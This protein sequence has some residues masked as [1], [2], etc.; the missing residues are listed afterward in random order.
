M[1]QKLEIEN[2]KKRFKDIV[3]SI[4]RLD[5]SSLS[6]L[7]NYLDQTDF[8][9]APASTKYHGAYEGGLCEHS[10]NVY[11][12]LMKLYESFRFKLED[13]DVDSIAITALFHD[14]SKTNF[15]QKE[16]K[17][18]KVYDNSGNSRWEDYIGYSVIDQ[19]DRFLLGNHEENAAYLLST[20]IPLRA[21][22]YSAILNH[23]GGM[24]WD[25]SKVNIAEIFQYN[26]LAQFLHYADSIDAYDPKVNSI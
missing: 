18:R 8:F 19:S 14:L 11:D 1:L 7:L 17:H 26:P 5:E 2:N 21:S 15:Y 25:S 13:D 4:T 16:I 23:H 20:L 6:N 9:V 10:L 12:N 22:E 3:C 24:G